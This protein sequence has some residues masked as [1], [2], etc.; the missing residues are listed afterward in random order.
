[1][2]LLCLFLLFMLCSAMPQPVVANSVS[3][4]RVECT[5]ALNP[6]VPKKVK[7]KKPRIRKIKQLQYG[8]EVSWISI[9]VIFLTGILVL[10]FPNLLIMNIIGAIIIGLALLILMLDFFSFTWEI[11]KGVISFV[12][13]VLNGIIALLMF[14]TGLIGFHPIIWITGLVLLGAVVTTIAIALS[15]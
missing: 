14:I 6:R 8:G 11:S 12:F 2:R 3:I 7:K 9:F 4:E 13:G 1:M 15:Y 5:T 10:A